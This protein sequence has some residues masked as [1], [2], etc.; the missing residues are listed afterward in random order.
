MRKPCLLLLIS[1]ALASPF[2]L[3]EREGMSSD[4]MVGVG[5]MHSLK[6][7]KKEAW[8]ALF[9][10]AKK[11]N[12]VAMFHLGQLMM[13]SPEFDNNLGKAEKFFSAAAKRGHKGS[14]AMLSK[15]RAQL[16]A[17]TPGAVPTIAGVSGLPSDDD[18]AKAKELMAQAEA[19]VGRFVEEPRSTEAKLEVQTFVSAGK[20]SIATIAQAAD[21]LSARY[22]DDISFRYFV[23]I[24][25]STWDPKKVFDK[26]TGVRD[27]IGFEPDMDGVLARQYGIRNTPAIVIKQPNGKP[28][29]VSADSLSSEISKILN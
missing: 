4:D 6:G 8:E 24:D 19:K 3:A 13:T 12:V 27:L 28:R 1:M 23:V 20:Q 14:A 17:Q 5:I 29:I 7:E 16:V 15:V 18:I 2:A 21:D 22:G 25:Q 11:G 10:E 26:P 9:P